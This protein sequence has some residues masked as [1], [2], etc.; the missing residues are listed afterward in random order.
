MW[1]LK[2]VIPFLYVTWQGR[3]PVN[4][5]TEYVSPDPACLTLL[6]MMRYDR[7]L[8]YYCLA[9]YTP[10]AWQSF[11]S[12]ASQPQICGAINSKLTVLAE[13]WIYRITVPKLWCD[14][15]KTN[16]PI[17]YQTKDDDDSLVERRVML[18]RPRDTHPTTLPS[19]WTCE[20]CHDYMATPQ[21]YY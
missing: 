3:S 10:V 14:Q 6:R 12:I 13:F 11:G 19:Q 7:W 1:N 2:V 17:V 16:W 20:P 4:L 8:A 15:S 18:T 9:W 21:I 5:S